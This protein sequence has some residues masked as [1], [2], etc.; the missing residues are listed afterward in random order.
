MWYQGYVYVGGDQVDGGLYF[1]GFFDDGW[2][3]GVVGKNVQYLVCIVGMGFG[4][5]ENEMFFG[6]LCQCYFVVCQQWM[7][8]WEYCYQ[9]FFYDGFVED[10]RVV[11]GQVF[12][13]DIDVF[14]F[15]C[16]DLFY[17]YDFGKFDFDVWYVGVEMFDY[18]G[19]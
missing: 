16:F 7:V 5:I 2:L 4:W 12:E 10:V 9:W 15:E 3:Q 11:D 14:G 13:V 17:G 6:Q 19:Q 8:Q 1:V 18:F